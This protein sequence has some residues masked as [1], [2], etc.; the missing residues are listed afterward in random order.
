MKKRILCVVCVLTLLLTACSKTSVE[1]APKES[2]QPAA[3]TPPV[4]E[5]TVQDVN[6][7]E[8][9]TGPRE[10][11]GFDTEPHV[12]PEE[13]RI[14]VIEPYSHVAV[15]GVDGAGTFFRDADTPELDR[16]VEN[17]AITYRA[18]TSNPTISAQSWGS[19]LTGVVPE[20]HRLTNSLISER[21]YPAD[22]QFPTVFRVIREAMPDAKIGSF[23]TWNPI[24]VGIA[25]D[26]L[27]IH[28]ETASG[29][30]ELCGKICDYV[31]SEKPTFLFVQYDDVDATGH[32]VG[33][34]TEGHLAR[35][36]FTDGLIGRVHQAFEEAGIADDT[37]FIFTADHG[38]TG[39][40]HGG[41]SDAEKYI[42]I[43]AAGK[44]VVHGEIGD[45]EVRDIASVVLMGLGLEASQPESWTARVPSGLFEGVEARERPVY[46]IK[47]NYPH[48]THESS[49]TPEGDASV[50][51]LLGKD[52]IL[53]YL[54]FDGDI[55]P[56]AGL[57]RTKQGGKL[58]FTDGY[59]GQ[60]AVFDDG[61]V[62][63]G[64]WK[65]E[66]KSFSVALW[67]KTDGVF[68]DPCLL[69]NK[70]WMSGLNPGFV[71]ALRE[72][73]VKFNAGSGGQFR[74]DTE[75][76]LPID[77]RGGWVYVVLVVDRDAGEVRFSY[78]FAPLEKAAI[79]AELKNTSLNSPFELNIG[80]DGT[81]KI[82][83]HL[84]AALDEYLIVDGVLTDEDIAA[85]KAHYAP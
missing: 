54:P 2:S 79:P 17:G 71:L 6:E 83:L 12:E 75:Y 19:M 50:V 67:M 68:V 42:M 60:G 32:S 64:G 46:E 40:S 38:G 58:Y 69:S 45:V 51:N 81:G 1:T 59:F 23:A 8:A 5:S 48:R 56:G 3:V 43:A 78:D 73:D 33:Y 36:A 24:N 31:V 21:P 4:T 55:Q 74:M 72:G 47:Y 34:G 62:T 37:L 41:W 76:P 28:K 22:S 84:S 85:L 80:Q 9:K 13:E 70:D 27:N 20:C 16:I 25:D 61:Y 11:V 14:T 63:L 82:D 53:T 77:F 35:I 30:G 7:P 39:M 52:R 29:D 10:E 15:I 49:P 26:G 65:P 44:N 18:L 57:V 66:K